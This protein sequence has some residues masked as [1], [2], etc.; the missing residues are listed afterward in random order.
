MEFSE[1]IRKISNIQQK[2]LKDAVQVKLN[3]GY[4]IDELEVTYETKTT[5]TKDG[6]KTVVTYEIDKKADDK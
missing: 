2:A 5:K 4:T 6:L 3:E 1:F